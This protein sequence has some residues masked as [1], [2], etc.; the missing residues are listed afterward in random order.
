M[1]L[2]YVKHLEDESVITYYGYTF[3]LK[4]GYS[5]AFISIFSMLILIA[6]AGMVLYGR[7]KTRDILVDFYLQSLPGVA[8]KYGWT[9]PDRIAWINNSVLKTNVR[10]LFMG[11]SQK[12]AMAMRRFFEGYQHFLMAFGGLFV[13]FWL[14]AAATFFL[15]IIIAVSLIFFYK[16][17]RRASGATRGH[18]NI[19]GESARRARALLDDVSSWPNPYLDLKVLRGITHEGYNP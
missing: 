15:I 13:L 8:S 1:L 18:E 17:N 7:L 4:D 2:R 10:T 6:G 11:D 14:D 5:L 16:I 3:N 9:P 12:S 19:S